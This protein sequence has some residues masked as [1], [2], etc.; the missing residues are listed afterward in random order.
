MQVLFFPMLFYGYFNYI[1]LQVAY[2]IEFI[3]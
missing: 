1:F 3:D 2:H